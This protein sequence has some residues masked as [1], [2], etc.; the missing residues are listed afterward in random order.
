MEN[1]VKFEQKENYLRAYTEGTDS[2][3]FTLD[4][5]KRISDECVKRGLN[6]V[7][8]VENL[9]GQLSTID[10]FNV[11]KVMPSMFRELKVAFVDKHLQDHSLNLFGEDVAWNRGCYVKAFVNEDAA[12]DWLTGSDH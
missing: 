1:Q 4:Y 9:E 8:I 6:K 3:S 12:I 11:G 2:L 5:F 7:L 10:I